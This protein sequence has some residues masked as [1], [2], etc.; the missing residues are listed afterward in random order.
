MNSTGL[1]ENMKD[2]TVSDEAGAINDKIALEKN[3]LR[4]IWQAM[5]MQLAD[6]GIENALNIIP[7]PEE[8]EYT[9]ER[10][11]FDGSETLHG[12]WRDKKGNKIGEI[13]VRDNDSVYAEADVIRN[14]PTDGRWFVES[15]TAWGKKTDIKTEL[16]L[17]PAV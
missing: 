11:P 12:V 16:K 5:R 8:A 1:T 6:A 14:H 17:L 3:S 7:L 2:E 10:D 15:V 4:D 13:Q 9:V